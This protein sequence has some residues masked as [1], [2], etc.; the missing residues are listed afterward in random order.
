MFRYL[1]LGKFS[2]FV[3][4]LF[5]RLFLRLKSCF[6]LHSWQA[7]VICGIVLHFSLDVAWILEKQNP[8]G[9][10]NVD[11]SKQTVKFHYNGKKTN[12]IYNSEHASTHTYTMGAHTTIDFVCFCLSYFGVAST[13]CIICLAR[14]HT[15]E[16]PNHLHR[17]HSDIYNVSLFRKRRIEHNREKEENEAWKW[18]QKR[19]IFF[20][21]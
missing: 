16:Y 7:F 17:A 9:S 1:V 11:K 10:R 14:Q 13:H 19:V 21:T 15:T 18:K 12:N 8:P 5:K 2:V 20:S 4:R 6:L 3:S